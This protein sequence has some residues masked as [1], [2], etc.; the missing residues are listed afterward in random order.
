MAL[1]RFRLIKNIPF[2]NLAFWAYILIL[3][4]G[5]QVFGRFMSEYFFSI[6]TEKIVARVRNEMFSKMMQLDMAWYVDVKLDFCIHV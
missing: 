2:I 6:I 5:C 3:I 1:Y 4:G